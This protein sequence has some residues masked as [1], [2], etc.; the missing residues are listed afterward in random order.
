MVERT[1]RSPRIL[2]TGGA[3]FIGIHAV[4]ALVRTG[5]QVL[6]VDDGRHACGQ[7]LPAEVELVPEDLS[8]PAAGDAIARFRPQ[9]IVHLAAQG[10]ISRSLRDPAGDAL[11][12]VVA[13]V[14][15]LKAAV[16]AG[17]E[18]LVF[19]SSGGAVYGQAERL[20]TP[21]SAAANPLSP[22]GAAKLACEG[23]LGMFQRT[24]GLASVA[25]RFGNV[26]GP[27]Q[28]GSGE[29]GVIAI[30]SAR[31][32]EGDRPRIRGAGTQT[33][34]FVYVEDVVDAVLRALESD[35][36]GVVNVGSGMATSILDVAAR[37][38][39]LTGQPFA[40]VHVPMGGGEVRD[41][42]LDVR[43]AAD[44]LGWTART[45]LDEGL[46]VTLASFRQEAPPPAAALA[47][48]S[49]GRSGG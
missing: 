41:A 36:T 3:G 44:E 7:G 43:R 47:P 18:R 48:R 4:R 6:V 15:L 31:L 20:P 39:R 26:Y 32:I 9:R 16:D 14:A 40:P 21:E 49:E 11:A 22:Y 45:G 8:T 12:N 13:T 30:N 2:V 23:Y 5:H 34:D 28:D 27:H 33:R 37:L 46:A 19:A 35:L 1:R 17:S 42:C 38:S 10:G 29:A 24:F 25:L